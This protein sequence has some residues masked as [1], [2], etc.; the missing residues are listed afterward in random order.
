MMIWM[1]EGYQDRSG[2]GGACMRDQRSHPFS[3]DNL[4]HTLLGAMGVRTDFH[5]GAMDGLDTCRTGEN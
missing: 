5:K 2:I 4:Y 3:H 1:S